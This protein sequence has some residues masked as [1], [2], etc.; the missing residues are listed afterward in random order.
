MSSKLSIFKNFFYLVLTKGVDFAVPVL[1]LPILVSRL[2]FEQFGVLSFALAI[3]IYFTSFMQYGYNIN[4]VKDIASSRDDSA[5]LNQKFSTYFVSSWLIS[6]VGVVLFL[7]LFLIDSVSADWP[8]YSSV[9]LFSFCQ[10]IS[11]NWLFQGLEKMYHITWVNGVAKLLFFIGVYV[12]LEVPEQAYFVPLFQGLSVLFAVVLSLYIIYRQKLAEFKLPSIASIV[13]TYKEGWSAFVTQ[14]TPTLY[15]TSMVFILGV[16]QSPLIVGIYSAAIRVIEIAN[17]VAFLLMNAALPS[18]ARD[19]KQHVWFKKIMVLL[20]GIASLVLY[21]GISFVAP[22][23]FEQRTEQIIQL[24]QLASPM[25]LF[26]FFRLAFGP[27]YLMLI[28]R[29]AV[30]RNIVFWC[31]FIGFIAAC[32]LVP[33]YGINMAIYILLAVSSMMSVLT[34]VSANKKVVVG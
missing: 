16:T 2:G 8:L 1:L 23:L 26:V 32:A 6:L 34:F 15:S 11:P 17:A 20:G 30:Y 22:Y 25:L 4:A 29:E 12:F 21:F 33:P 10:G 7:P 31:S 27:A 3:G 14:V 28:G 9:I 18:L 19:I 13:N 24:I 5:S